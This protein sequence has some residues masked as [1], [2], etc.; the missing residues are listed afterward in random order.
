MDETRPALPAAA[1]RPMSEIAALTKPFRVRHGRRARNAGFRLRCAV[2]R[3]GLVLMYHRIAVPGA[4]PW[5][6]AVS[7][8]NFAAHL[9]VMRRHGQC[10]SLGE[11]A[12]RIAAADRPRRMIAVTFDDGYRDNLLAGLPALA[13]HDVPATIFVVSSTT[14]AGRDFWWDALARVFLTMPD[15]P[16]ELSLE[17]AGTLH[18]WQL[19]AAAHCSP[20]ALG[21]LAH[22]SQL[23]DA[24]SHPRQTVFLGVWAV[25]NALPMAQA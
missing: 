17:V 3:H 1:L 15:L 12:A 2:Q 22:W 5:D 23:H 24:V 10:V 21:A 19:G 6:L 13:A 8:A 20:A 9:E 4:D 25:L 7:P 14:G 16:A 11:F 18:S